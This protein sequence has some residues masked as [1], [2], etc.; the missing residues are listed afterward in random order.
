V[1]DVGEVPDERRLERRP[2]PRQRIV[3]EGLEQHPR[4]LPRGGEL[5]LEVGDGEQRLGHSSWDA[6]SPACVS[7]RESQPTDRASDGGT[8]GILP[9]VLFDVLV[10]AR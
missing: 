4:R 10:L 5:G 1:T 7:V 8:R 3:V 2:L 9:T 6:R